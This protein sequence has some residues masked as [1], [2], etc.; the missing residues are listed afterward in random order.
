MKNKKNLIVILIALVMIGFT[1]AFFANNSSFLNSF[2]T[3]SFGTTFIETF[4]SPNNWSPGTTTPVEFIVKNSKQTPIAVRMSYTEKW[5][6]DNNNEIDNVKDGVSAGIINFVNESD[7]IKDGDYY[8]YKHKLVYNQAASN[9]IES[10]TYNSNISSDYICNVQDLMYDVCTS[11]T[12]EY[13]GATY[14]LKVKFE[15]MQYKGYK[16]AWNTLVE[17]D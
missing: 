10:V 13:N 9:P 2:Q 12:G 6:D 1:V 16:D 11:S 4:E 17:I 3:K 14:Y 5:I 8:Y 7:W 15:T